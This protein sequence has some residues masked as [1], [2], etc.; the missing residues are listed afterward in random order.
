MEETTHVYNETGCVM[1]AVR[2]VRRYIE[3][4][5]DGDGDGDGDGLI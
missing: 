2:M 1:D 5:G 4:G 3:T